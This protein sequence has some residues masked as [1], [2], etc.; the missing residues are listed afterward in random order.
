MNKTKVFLITLVGA[1]TLALMGVVVAKAE[2]Y[3]KPMNQSF[4]TK[5]QV[6]YAFE[7]KEW[8]GTKEQATKKLKEDSKFLE[9]VAEKYKS[10]YD[11]EKKLFDG[12]TVLTEGDMIFEVLNKKDPLGLS[13]PGGTENLNEVIYN[14]LSK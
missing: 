13:I 1:L 8:K 10:K 7:G 2:P 5:D 4:V 12:L 9:A 11:K 14:V 6:E 3:D